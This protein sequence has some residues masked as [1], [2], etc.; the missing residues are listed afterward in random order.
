[1]DTPANRKKIKQLTENK[2]NREGKIENKIK[3]PIDILFSNQNDSSPQEIASR[4]SNDKTPTPIE[5]IHNNVNAYKNIFT[6]T[7]CNEKN[8][9]SIIDLNNLSVKNNP[10]RVIYNVDGKNIVLNKAQYISKGSYGSV[11]RLFNESHR[12]SIA[13]KKMED[14]ND[15]EYKIIK[16]LQKDGIG[17]DILNVKV[18]TIPGKGKMIF[19]DFYNGSLY[20]LMGKLNFSSILNIIKQLVSNLLCLY[21]NGYVYTDLKPDNILYKCVSDKHFKI[22]IGDLGSICKKNSTNISTYLPWDQRNEQPYQI[23]CKE[24]S[25]VWG[26]G[27]LFM[28]LIAINEDNERMENLFLFNKIKSFEQSRI[29]LFVKYFITKYKLNDILINNGVYASNLL[30]NMLNLRSSDRITLQGLEQILQ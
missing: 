2:V 11:Y 28:L 21:N 13:M 7:S 25:V 17:C 26:L 10:T 3:S 27:I 15:N 23:R 20:E 29:I 30:E 16:K 22:T 9:Y 5:G 19:S 4:G 1:M 8:K 14:P 18:L 24:S 6:L 12:I